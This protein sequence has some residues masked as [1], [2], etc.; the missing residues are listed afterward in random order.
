MGNNLFDKLNFDYFKPLAGHNRNFYADLGLALRDTL[1][2][3][4]GL[5]AL[6][7]EVYDVIQTQ[8]DKYKGLLE[9]EEIEDES[10]GEVG[11]TYALTKEIAYRKIK[12]CGWIK[13]MDGELSNDRIVFIPDDSD[14]LI[15]ALQ[16]IANPPGNR[17]GGYCKN[18]ADILHEL[19]T[20]SV[21]MDRLEHPYQDYIRQAES[22]YRSI[23][24]S[25]LQAKTDMTD[26]IKTVLMT[27]QGDAIWETIR[28]GYDKVLN[29]DIRLILVK[30]GLN[31]NRRLAIR[32]S[33]ERI[34]DNPSLMDAI[35]MDKMT[36][37]A[38][39]MSYHEASANV[40]DKMG[41]IMYALCDTFE[42]TVNDLCHQQSKYYQTAVKKANI[43]CFDIESSRTG[44]AKLLSHLKEMD[45][46]TYVEMM[47]SD[48]VA[49]G[50]LCSPKYIMSTMDRLYSPKTRM[51]MQESTVDPIEEDEFQPLNLRK[52]LSGRV[53]GPHWANR[54]V[55][56]ILKD[57]DAVSVAELSMSDRSDFVDL[58]AIIANAESTKAKYQI[59]FSTQP[60]DT[61][62][63]DGNAGG[64]M[65]MQ[66]CTIPVFTIKRKG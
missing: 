9:Q 46:E 55:S 13:E 4:P 18:I 11:R 60:E 30:E 19:E 25:V 3:Q 35:V 33:L 66:G 54:K 58:V 42:Q 53:R 65:E 17:I 50:L 27:E 10:E 61:Y 21:D 24:Q 40:R 36:S 31:Y 38:N 52:E 8:L 48:P 22:C 49:R 64:Y 39:E 16:R 12:K 44:V 56:D 41:R 62:Y 2:A 1:E 47:D 6:R 37:E 51:E 63:I 29:G 20:R 34:L 14:V 57:R 32:E 23:I 26:R 15:T 43:Y 59:V 45:D 7:S 28:D 5:Q